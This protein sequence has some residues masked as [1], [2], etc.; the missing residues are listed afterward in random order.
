MLMSIVLTIPAVGQIDLKRR[1]V[2]KREITVSLSLANELPAQV[3]RVNKELI[4]AIKERGVNFA[5]SKYEEWA[6]QLQ[7]ASDELIK[8]IREAMSPEERARRLDESE[9]EKLYYSFMLNHTRSDPTSQQIALTS[10][11]EFVRRYKGRPAEAQNIAI[12]ERSL[13]ALESAVRRSY[14]RVRT[15]PAR[16]RSN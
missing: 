4:A 5:L 2:T 1:P 9:R 8:T 12:I 15:A 14:R 16:R 11:R 10:G 3:L 7:D 6:L 13:P